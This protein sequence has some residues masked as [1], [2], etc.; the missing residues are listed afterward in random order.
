MRLKAKKN[1][2]S[3]AEPLRLLLVLLVERSKTQVM[4]RCQPL[5]ARKRVFVDGHKVI[6]IKGRVYVHRSGDD[7]AFSRK[8]W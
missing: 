3:K 4:L 6:G 1:K 7:N 2:E 5:S 8:G